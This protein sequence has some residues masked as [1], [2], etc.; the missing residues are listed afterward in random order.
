VQILLKSG[1][2]NLLEP[3]GPVKAS[4][5]IALPLTLLINNDFL[6][7]N[8]A[9]MRQ[10]MRTAGTVEVEWRQVLRRSVSTGVK[11]DETS[12]GRV[13]AAGFHYVTARSRLAGVLKLMN[14]L[15][16]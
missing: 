16:I 15:S 7:P 14:R 1:N 6:N 3:S 4:N 2:L 8:T 13:W 12:T 10:L 9:I 11:E 5:G